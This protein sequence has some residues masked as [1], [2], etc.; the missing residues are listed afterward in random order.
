MPDNSSPQGPPPDGWGSGNEPTIPYGTPPPPRHAAPPPAWYA[1]P[2]PPPPPR[3]R[4]G[5]L[6]GGIAAFVVALVGAGGAVILATSGSGRDL[7]TPPATTTPS[8]TEVPSSAPSS[9]GPSSTAPVPSGSFS[10]GL[11]TGKPTTTPTPAEKQR[12]L[13]DV[14]RGAHVY[15]DVY[16]EP[17]K[18]WT[19]FKKSKYTMSFTA[20]RK[21]FF[22]VYVDPVG[23]SARTGVTA[24][25]TGLAKAENMAGVRKGRVQ[26]LPP[27]NSNISEQATVSFSGRARSSEVT[28]SLVGRCT[29]MTGVE[30]IHN[31]TVTACIMTFKDDPD[32]AL[33]DGRKMLASVARSI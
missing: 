22:V 21:G 16:V 5:W 4:N 19:R 6:V 9:S 30:S 25:V 33:A 15:D 27:A 17:V 28:L 11:T 14:D 13:R 26:T 1:A 20:Y 2:P 32:A 12:T 3:K 23:Y 7:S 18:G 10:D 29:T 24:F 31:V 8:E